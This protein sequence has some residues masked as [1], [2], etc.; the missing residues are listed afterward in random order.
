MPSLVLALSAVFG[1]DPQVA[2]APATENEPPARVPAASDPKGAGSPGF[3]AAEVALLD[4]LSLRTLPPPPPSPSNRVADDRDAAELGHRLFFDAG[5]SRNGSIACATCHVPSLRFTDGRATSHGL[6]PT[7]RN[8]PTLVGSAHSPWQ[9][10]DGR[11]DSL[12]SQALAPMEAG[13]EM[14][15]TRLAAVRHVA[16]TPELA[17][18]YEAL[19]GALPALDDAERFPP[20]AGPFGSPQEKDAWYRMSVADRKA[21]DTAFANIGKALAAYERLLQPAPSRFDRYVEALRAGRDP[22]PEARL[23]AEEIAGLALF[24][25]AGRSL[26]LRCHNGPLLTNH[27]FHDI[28]TAVGDTRLPDFGRFLGLQAVLIDPFNCLGPFSDASPNECRELR[29]IETRHAEGEMGKFKTPTLRGLPRTGPYMHDGRFATLE[30][31]IDHY[32]FP[33]ASPD[34]LEITPLDID[35]DEARSLVAFLRT[36]DGGSAAD[37]AWLRPPDDELRAAAARRIRLRGS[38]R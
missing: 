30:E 28:G 32:R 7:S 2:D 21:V 23:D 8:A 10:W 15:T 4:S 35:D 6:G 36:L 13:V 19:F 31:V 9:F 16:S 20:S 1:C 22:E 38:S 34:P 33:P 29:F 11:R 26:C 5:L 14:G 18:R 37:E 24:V 17:R 27:V 25:D 3:D 12:W